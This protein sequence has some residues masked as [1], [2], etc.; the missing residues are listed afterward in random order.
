MILNIV[1]LGERGKCPIDEVADGRVDADS[2]EEGRRH[3]CL[4]DL[5]RCCRNEFH[6]I[7]LI[8]EV[9]LGYL[10]NHHRIKIRSHRNRRRKGCDDEWSSNQEPR[11][12]SKSDST[13]H[14]ENQHNCKAQHQ[15][16]DKRSPQTQRCIKPKLDCQENRIEQSRRAQVFNETHLQVLQVIKK[17]MDDVTMVQQMTGCTREEANRALLMN[18]TVVDA[19]AALIPAN[20][21][22]SGNKY[23]PAK[24]KVDT[25]MDAEQVALCERGRW[26]QDKVNAVFS[27][28]HSKTLPDQ[29]VGQSSQPSVEVSDLLPAVAVVEESESSQG[30][31][32]QTAQPALQSETPQ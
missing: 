4:L 29:P 5:V 3:F 25:G 1:L 20:P 2:A 14:V 27:V 22:I 10:A 17:K 11:H 7:A 19:V 26:L 30:N 32:A 21:V 8:Q 18:E 31:P 23:I 9:L 16:D 28:A 6:F 13:E 12:A 24:P 15:L